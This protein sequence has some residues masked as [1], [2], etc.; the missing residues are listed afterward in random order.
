MEQELLQRIEA[1]EQELEALRSASTIPYDVDS[2]FRERFRLNN[3]TIA[4]VSSK[5]NDS[6]DQAVNEGGSGTY[7]VLKPPDGFLQI[8]INNTVYYL[9]FFT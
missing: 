5:A 7:S 2:A 3:V 1:L 9:P 8:T 6:E 4:T